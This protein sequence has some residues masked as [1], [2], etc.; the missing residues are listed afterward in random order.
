MVQFQIG[1]RQTLSVLVVAFALLVVTHI[2]MANKDRAIALAPQY[3]QSLLAAIQR[4]A[5]FLRIET[6]PTWATLRQ[7]IL[8]Q[9]NIPKLAGS[10]AALA[11]SMIVGVIVVFLYAV[12]LCRIPKPIE[13]IKHL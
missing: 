12:F 2:V 9:I 6:E 3:Q 11:S 4:V 8:A 7:D 10:L 13:A 5:V 1:V